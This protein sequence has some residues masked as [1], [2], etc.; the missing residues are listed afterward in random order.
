[1]NSIAKFFAVIACCV[2][3]WV[4]AAGDVP[5]EKVLLIMLDGCRADAL[6][7]ADMPNARKL[8]EGKWQK[9][10][11]GLYSFY[12][13][14]V[15]DAP[16]H[17]APNH[18]SLATG[19]KAAKHLVW[20]NGYTKKGNFDQYPHFLSILCDKYP[21]LKAAYHYVWKESGMI[22][23]GNKNVRYFN[24]SDAGVVAAGKKF[25]ETGDALTIYINLP[26]AGGHYGGFYPYHPY[27]MQTLA[28]CDQWIGEMLDVIAKRKDFANENWLICLTADHGGYFTSHGHKP[29]TGM[30]ATIPLIIC[31]K[32]V[33]SGQIAGT[34]YIFD[35]AP[36]IM[37]HFNI[38]PAS[39]NMDGIV[40]GNDIFV[41]ANA[42]APL[43]KDLQKIVTFDLVANGDLP[44][45]SEVKRYVCFDKALV[46]NGG[47]ESFV[48]KDSE[49]IKFPDNNFTITFWAKV[50]V[51]TAEDPLI[52]SSKSTAAAD[53]N[54]PGLAL[55]A[56]RNGDHPFIKRGREK[57]LFLNVGSSGEKA[58]NM[59]RF[60]RNDGW[61][62]YAVTLDANKTLLFAT[63]S[64]DGY[65]YY[66]AVNGEKTLPVS[67]Q[68]F[69]FGGQGFTGA[70]DDI[71]IWNR[72]LSR[73]QLEK[74]Y[75]AGRAGLDISKLVK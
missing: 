45:K 52:F 15:S 35:V 30:G 2:A 1:M 4:I 7:N 14:S 69:R 70:V 5:Q 36:T 16:T 42:N 63:G 55:Y 21:A 28:Q 20:R 3:G 46:F 61:N 54:K 27:Y 39:K 48:V 33:K 8:A 75:R 24:S 23:S 58:I 50:P 74:I 11:N 53:E 13:Q 43:K 67:G 22:R 18:T 34:P 49:K 73:D 37:K 66:M 56:Y 31:G 32:N 65:F 72:S 10:Y 9:N 44:G 25:L 6:F 12:A 71:A 19:V 60:D 41:D 68:A 29:D 40:L 26:D 17:S 47:T 51:Q 38:D 57:G 64:A 62:F 59:S